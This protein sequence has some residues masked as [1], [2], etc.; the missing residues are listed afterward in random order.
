MIP[1]APRWRSPATAPARRQPTPTRPADGPLRAGASA[2]CGARRTSARWCRRS[3]PLRAADGIPHRLVLAGVD[4][5]EGPR[6]REL[7]GG[8]AGGADRLRRR[9][10][11]DA[12]LAG[13]ELLVH[14]SLYEGF[15]LVVLEAMARG[16]PV[17]A[18]R[19]TALPETGGD[20]AEYFDPSTRPTS[21]AAWA[22]CWAM[23]GDERRWPQR[24][25]A[26]AARFTWA[27]HRARD[28]R[29]STASCVETT[30]D[31]PAAERRRGADAR[32]LAAGGAGPGAG[33]RGGG[34]RQRLH[35]RDGAAGRSATACA[36]SAIEPRRS[37][38]AAI[39]QAIAATGG[40]RGAA[41][42][43]R[44]LSARR[45][46]WPRRCR[47]WP[48]P[49]VGS[50]APKLVRAARAGAGRAGPREID[51][52]GMFVDRRRKNGLVGH[53]RAAGA[54]HRD[55]RR[56][57]APTARRRCTGARRSR[58]ARW[59]AARCST[60][61]W[62]CGPRTPTWPGGRS[63]AAGAAS[64][65][66]ARSP[67]TCAPTARRTRARMS[68]EARRLQFRNRYLMMI[69]NETGGRPGARRRRGSRPTS[70]WRS[71]TCCCA[72][73]TCWP[74]TGTPGGC[75][76]GA[77]RRRR[78]VQARA[79]GVAAVR[80]AAR[81]SERRRRRPPGRGARGA[82]QR[83]RVDL[84]GGARR[85]RSQVHGGRRRRGP[86]QRLGGGGPARRGRRRR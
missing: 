51:A 14:P 62:S 55:R 76:R 83:L 36:G 49:G 42:Q 59:A 50:V 21:S 53:G 70:C 1:E 86:A 32:A 82:E 79:A 27:A 67:S 16:T 19:A 40:R 77:R 9:R 80:P 57:S 12:L 3:W 2:T 41:A 68:E 8:R 37:Y 45:G 65:S 39:N 66:R 43:R 18:A 13:A 78:L 64:T 54:L 48:R 44:L 33:G 63:C 23:P 20:A 17:L 60:R 31:D 61:T 5:G 84:P 75:A 22:R 46:S 74:A 15:G 73:A 71:A 29:T 24:G 85:R 7:A 34:G 47:G 35:R 56:R 52:A 81:R 69:K 25:R 38:A 58:T 28:R 11:L 4:A 72:S 26:R 10:R 30:D 6:L